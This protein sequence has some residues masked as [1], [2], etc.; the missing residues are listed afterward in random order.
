M[1]ELG[2]VPVGRVLIESN[3]VSQRSAKS[4]VRANDVTVNGVQVKDAGFLVDCS[5]DEVC[6]N[7]K[8]LPGVEHVYFAFNKP[9]GVVCSTVSD[10]HK[11]VYDFVRE[12]KDVMAKLES[13]C[14]DKK[15]D[16]CLES[17]VQL[18]EVEHPEFVLHSAG[19][20]DCDT[21]GLLI[22]SS[23]GTFTNA[24]TRPEN[25]I[26]KTYLV[27][28]ENSVSSQEQKNYIEKIKAGVKVPPEKKSL[29]F[30]ARGADVVF[31]NSTLCE[32]TVTEGKFHEVRRI[33]AVLGNRVFALKRIKFFEFELGELKSGEFR[34]IHL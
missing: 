6:V 32:I 27:T 1:I 34:E 23:N 10:S 19:R 2:K 29:G 14:C 31:R 24:L 5:C 4:F 20:L 13:F 9:A 21:E 18:N 8:V 25:N 30:T 12:N 26:E 11:T 33:F 17:A 3:I 22:F 7:G 28:L 16:V 15:I